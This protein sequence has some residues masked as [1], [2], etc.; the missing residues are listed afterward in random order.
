M[1]YK[2]LYV[3]LEGNDD[4][5][6]FEGIIKAR[7]SSQ[8]SSIQVWQYAQKPPKKTKNF[9]KAITAIH[10]DYFFW[11]DINDLP[12]V[13]ARKEKIR[14][15]YGETIDINNLI[16][17]I[18]E[19]ESW[20]LAGLDDKKCQELGLGTFTHTHD[21]AKEQFN[22]LIPKKFDSRI[23]FMA[24]ILKRFSVETAKQKNASFSYFMRKI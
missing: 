1:E 18:E 9:L 14:D 24:E 19:I 3:L 22:S 8:Y 4:E 15:K 20:Y 11:A 2:R 6:F 12:C 5:R 17:V 10:S 7:L 16:I 23:D 21:I 13:T